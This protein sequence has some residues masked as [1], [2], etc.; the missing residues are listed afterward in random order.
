[1]VQFYFDGT[2]TGGTFKD[3]TYGI[4]IDT[5]G[6]YTLNGGTFSGNTKDINVTASSGI[7]NITTDVSGLTYQTAGATVNIIAPTI[8]LT[9]SGANN[10]SEIRVYKVS[11]DTELMGIENSSGDFTDDCSYVGVVKIIVHHLDYQ[12]VN[13]EYTLTGVDANVPVPQQKDLTYNN[14][15]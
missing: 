4:E 15:A 1:M 3:N 10:N 13:F 6:D 8:T 2:I 12:Y 14:P 5:A 9:I 7:V 11:D